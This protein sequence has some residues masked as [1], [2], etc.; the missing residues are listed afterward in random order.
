MQ[1][2]R[3]VVET[4]HSRTVAAVLVPATNTV[5]GQTAPAFL[6]AEAGTWGD[7]DDVQME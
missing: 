3:A 2:T 1:L 7:E 5:V 4:A 6:A